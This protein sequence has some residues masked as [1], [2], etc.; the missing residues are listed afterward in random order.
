[1]MTYISQTFKFS[2]RYLDIY[3][4]FLSKLK[5]FAKENEKKIRIQYQEGILANANLEFKTL[6]YTLTNEISSGVYSLADFPH[7]IKTFDKLKNNVIF[8]II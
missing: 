2:E 4:I 5:E 6:S 7:F 8:K 1:M 3:E